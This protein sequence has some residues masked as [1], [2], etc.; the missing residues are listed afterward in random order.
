MSKWMDYGKEAVEFAAPYVKQ[1]GV[2]AEDAAGRIGKSYRK[3][4]RRMKREMRMAKACRVM[5]FISDLFL[6]LAA[7]AALIALI[8]RFLEDAKD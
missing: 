4:K 6:M 3:S 8:Q 5:G 7:V 2:Y 1:V